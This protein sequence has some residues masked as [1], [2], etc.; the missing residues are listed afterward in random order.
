MLCSD[1]QDCDDHSNVTNLIQNTYIW[2]NGITSFGFSKLRWKQWHELIKTI[3]QKFPWKH[4]FWK[5]WKTPRNSQWCAVNS[6]QIFRPS[7]QK[8]LKHDLP[9]IFPG[10]IYVC[11]STYPNFQCP[12][13]ILNT[14]TFVLR[15]SFLK[16][17]IFSH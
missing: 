13:T 4:F 7:L 16:I 2:F 14:F 11:E 9:P 8:L 6:W 3:S 10:I 1:C 15:C 5:F 12:L 17:T